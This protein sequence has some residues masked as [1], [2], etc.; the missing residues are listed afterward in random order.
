MENTTPKLHL[1]NPARDL[2]SEYASVRRE[3]G[4]LRHEQLGE[5]E[6]CQER[7]GWLTQLLD[8]E[9]LTVSAE[10][11]KTRR[12]SDDILAAKRAF[13]VEGYAGA[14]ITYEVEVSIRESGDW[15][16]DYQTATGTVGRLTFENQTECF[17]ELIKMIGVAR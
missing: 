11:F 4:L 9:P 13:K 3:L 5:I 12:I 6:L 17:G 1:G 2:L 16:I 7:L 8:E 10:A 15:R 14:K